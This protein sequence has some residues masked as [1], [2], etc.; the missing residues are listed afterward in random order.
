MLV[1]GESPAPRG[2]RAVTGRRFAEL[3]GVERREDA[4]VDWTNL[5]GYDGRDGRGSRF[6]V[7]LAR[8]AAAELEPTLSGY[9]T[10][11][12]LGRRVERAFSFWPRPSPYFD[13]RAAAGT[14]VA[15]FPHPSGVNRYWNDPAAV[16][17]A[18]SFLW[19]VLSDGARFLADRSHEA[20]DE[21][22]RPKM[23][24]KTKTSPKT[25]QARAQREAK[26]TGAATP[27]RG[28]RKAAQPTTTPA[29]VSA[30]TPAETPEGESSPESAPTKP[31]SD[32][33]VREIGAILDGKQTGDGAIEALGLDRVEK[34]DPP[35]SAERAEAATGRS[36]VAEDLFDELFGEIEKLGATA[37]RKKNY[38][39][40][41]RDG[42]TPAYL[43]Q[44]GEKA[45]TVRVEV[46]RN[47]ESGYENQRVASDADAEKALASVRA[48]AEFVTASKAAA[49]SAGAKK[50]QTAKA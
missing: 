27:K 7:D 10:V 24:S 30:P 39:R 19:R 43:H 44:P 5:L 6:R 42:G 41:T 14:L 32:D 22:R 15:V 26:A 31:T 8:T 48:R 38:V 33:V 40:F 13:L 12:L 4:P 16:E 37:E 9:R 20:A 28:R 3:A 23:A 29:P 25:D 49:P 21:P 47:G 17:R 46:P 50:K 18:R 34:L 45:K 11:L 35:S 1:V 36:A 2:D